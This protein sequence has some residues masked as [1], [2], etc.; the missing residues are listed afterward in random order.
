MESCGSTHNQEEN[1]P[2][3]TDEESSKLFGKSQFLTNLNLTAKSVKVSSERQHGIA[4]QQAIE[5][6]NGQ[7]R[8]GKRLK[9]ALRR[10]TQEL[11]T[12]PEDE[13]GRV[14]EGSGRARMVWNMLRQ[15]QDPLQGAVCVLKNKEKILVQTKPGTNKTFR[16]KPTAL[17]RIML[18]AQGLD[19]DA[20][21][22]QEFCMGPKAAEK[23]R[24]SG[25][26]MPR[27]QIKEQVLSLLALLVQKYN[28]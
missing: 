25:L 24:T 21:A 3:H 19:P 28:Y 20:H 18:E 10:E 23:L 9:V 7:E 14:L 17:E 16:Q 27:A 15:G 2:S 13:L 12:L 11:L 22:T 1:T 6:M 26:T 8:E 4:A 5:G